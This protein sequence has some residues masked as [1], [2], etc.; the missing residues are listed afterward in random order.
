MI[1]VLLPPR[2]ESDPA[3]I[4]ETLAHLDERELH[5]VDGGHMVAK[6]VDVGLDRHR[7]AGVASSLKHSAGLRRF[8]IEI[9]G[10][11]WEPRIA[12]KPVA[13]SDSR[14]AL[15]CEITFSAGVGLS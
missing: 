12:L 1:P 8:K 3:V 6:E 4:D 5:S 2:L 11:K 10:A 9:V 7:L 15:V 13:E 14:D